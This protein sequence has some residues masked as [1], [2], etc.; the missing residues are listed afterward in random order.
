MLLTRGGRAIRFEE[1]DVPLQGRT[2]QGVRGIGLQDDD[3]VVGVILVRRDASV[4]TMTEEGMGKRTALSEFPLQKRGG[5]GTLAVPAGA[6]GLGLVGALEVVPGDEVTV[7]SAGGA[8]TQLEADKVPEQGRRTRGNRL[9]RLAAGDRVVEVTHSV[10]RGR[11]GDDAGVPDGGRAAESP[12][13]AGPGG[14]QAEL[15]T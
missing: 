13:E 10:G 6:S 14:P 9:V 1:K 8:V 12:A 5:L 4:F 3:A 2:A 7:V 15:F 11:G